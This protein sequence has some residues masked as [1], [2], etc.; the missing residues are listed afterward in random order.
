MPCVKGDRLECPPQSNSMG[1]TR[2]LNW[3][4]LENTGLKESVKIFLESCN[5]KIKELGGAKHPSVLWTTN[6]RPC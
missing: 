4:N 6:K 3:N 1:E 5:P 2:V